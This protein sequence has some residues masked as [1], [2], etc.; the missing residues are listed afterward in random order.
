MRGQNR[1]EERGI[2]T[3]S[4]G[5]KSRESGWLRPIIGRGKGNELEWNDFMIEREK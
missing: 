1:N 2:W 3:E 4:D 5:E